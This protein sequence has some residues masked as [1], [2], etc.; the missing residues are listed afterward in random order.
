MVNCLKELER[1]V[2]YIETE[3]SIFSNQRFLDICN[4]TDYNL[5]QS[6]DCVIFPHR[7]VYDV[8]SQFSSYLKVEQ[9][10]ND[11]LDVGLICIDSFTSLF[12]AKYRKREQYPER[13][14]EFSR[15]MSYLELLASKY[16]VAILMTDQVMGTPDVSSQYTNLA[17]Y[18]DVVRPYGGSYL[19]CPTLWLN[20]K[21]K[22]KKG[23]EVACVD[24]SEFAKNVAPFTI[25]KDGIRDL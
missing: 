3:P 8:D 22:S 17:R 11:G 25:T 2:V 7:F 9:L 1:K 20:V 4:G 13:S 23:Y 6:E 21:Q 24:S 14:S 10:I 15:H 16:N 12:R 19:H 5:N 18:N